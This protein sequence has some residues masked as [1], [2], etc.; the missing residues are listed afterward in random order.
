MTDTCGSG[1]DEHE[2]LVKIEFDVTHGEDGSIT[3]GAATIHS[4]VHNVPPEAAATTLVAAAHKILSDHMAHTTFG[5]CPSHELA[6][7]MASAAASAMLAQAAND[8]P[9]NGEVIPLVVPDDI[10]SLVEGE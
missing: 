9:N 6:H 8:T 10:S 5:E 4:H 1:E 7:A 3:A 2:V